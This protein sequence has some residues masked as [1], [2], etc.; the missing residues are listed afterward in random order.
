M[1][2]VGFLRRHDLDVELLEL[3]RID[4]ARCG[5]HEVL[6]ALRLRESDDVADVGGACEQHDDAVDPGCNAPMRRDAILESPEQETEPLLDP[7]LVRTRER[8]DAPLPRR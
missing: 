6:H 3:R 5:E 1:L 2:P 8:E 4:W 7:G